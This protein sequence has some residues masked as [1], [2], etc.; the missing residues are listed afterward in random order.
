GIDG[1][2]RVDLLD[3]YFPKQGSPMRRSLRVVLVDR[4]SICHRLT[5]RQY[6]ELYD[7]NLA[8]PQFANERLR[9]VEA[10]LDLKNRRPVGFVRILLRYCSFDSAGY[11]DKTKIHEE[12]AARMD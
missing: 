6:E 8:M 1:R 3:L 9:M 2:R 11:L 10:V 12:V 7:G 5:L 4:D